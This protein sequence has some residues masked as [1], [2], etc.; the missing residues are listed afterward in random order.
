MVC[1]VLLMDKHV[2]PE[3]EQF[4]AFKAL[5]RDKPV[6]MLNLVR[7]RSRAE[8]PGDHA[9]ASAGL[10]GAEAYRRYGEQSAPV[11][12]GVGGSILWSGRPE[13]VLIGPR[14]ERWDTAFVAYYPG[15][16]AFLAMVTDPEYKLAVV[17]RQAA[18]ETS[19]LIRTEPRD[20]GQSFA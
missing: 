20:G 11:F 1:Q 8:Y 17:H 9:L 16:G 14:S 15:A 2:D 10:S 12:R 3:R 6:A 18:V 5:Q 4:E 19:R 13:L 7:F